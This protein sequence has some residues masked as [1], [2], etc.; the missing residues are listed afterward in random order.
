MKNSGAEDC[1]IW[2]VIYSTNIIIVRYH[3]NI[4]SNIQQQLF[5]SF[6]QIKLG[7]LKKYKKIQ[8]KYDSMVELSEYDIKFFAHMY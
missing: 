2:G 8:V 7:L 1:M 6:I 3:N 5:S 4:S